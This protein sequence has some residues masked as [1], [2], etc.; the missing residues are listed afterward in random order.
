MYQFY[1]NSIIFHLI[2]FSRNP[3]C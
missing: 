1:N 2:D 3:K